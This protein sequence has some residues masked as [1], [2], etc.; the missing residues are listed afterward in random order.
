VLGKVRD[1]MGADADLLASSSAGDV[2]AVGPSEAY[3]R[4]LL[5][6]GRLGDSEVYRNVVRESDRAAG[7]L[8]V[9]FDAAGWLDSLASDDPELAT[10][11]KPLQ[12]L[13]VSTWVDGGVSHAVLRVTTD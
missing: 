7:V 5:G 12:G 13:G 3:R 1:R 8:F 10:N 9:D 6:D 11:L 4:Q 2:V